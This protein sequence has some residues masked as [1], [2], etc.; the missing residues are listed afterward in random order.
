MRVVLKRMIFCPQETPMLRSAVELITCKS[1]LKCPLNDAQLQRDITRVVERLNYLLNLS[2]NG[3]GPANVFSEC[4]AASCKIPA[5]AEADQRVPFKASWDECSTSL[6]IKLVPQSSFCGT[7]SFCGVSRSE[8]LDSD[9]SCS[10]TTDLTSSQHGTPCIFHRRLSPRVS[11]DSGFFSYVKVF[12]IHSRSLV[13][14][15]H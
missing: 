12:A 10:Q 5:N 14:S 6:C 3:N 1:Q 15:S 4:S 11:A 7:S 13:T 8:R 2:D 9:L